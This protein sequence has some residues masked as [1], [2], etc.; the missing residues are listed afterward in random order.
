MKKFFAL[1]IISAIFACAGSQAQQQNG[2]QPNPPVDNAMNS[3]Y[4]QS[5]VYL[6]IFEAQNAFDLE[7]KINQYAIDTNSFLIRVSIAIKENPHP[8]FYG[9]VLFGRE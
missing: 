7:K 5:K 9:A 1:M 2:N 4:S 8:V 6:K 3:L